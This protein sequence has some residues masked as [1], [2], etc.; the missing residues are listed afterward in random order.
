MESVK[1]MSK[2]IEKRL[3]RIERRLDKRNEPFL[4]P[5]PDRPGE[6]IEFTGVQT[7]A[8]LV[9]PRTKNNLIPVKHY[10]CN[11]DQEHRESA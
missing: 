7:L 1:T 10:G 5:D 2:S 9:Q 4:F 6:F 3:E 8:D 11:N